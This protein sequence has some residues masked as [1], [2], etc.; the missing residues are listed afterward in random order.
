MRKDEVKVSVVPVV[1]VVTWRDFWHFNSAKVEFR[2][3]GAGAPQL[4]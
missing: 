4:K 2:K 1:T 3:G